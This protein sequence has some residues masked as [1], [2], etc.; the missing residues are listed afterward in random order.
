MK[1]SHAQALVLFSGLAIVGLAL[2][3]SHP[4][5]AAISGRGGI[6]DNPA[7]ASCFITSGSQ[8]QGTVYQGC[9][10]PRRLCFNPMIT[11]GGNHNISAEGDSGT[12]SCFATAFYPNGAQANGTSSVTLVHPVQSTITTIGTVNVPAFGSLSICCDMS[13]NSILSMVN[14]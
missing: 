8:S 7:D 9:P 2:V 14:F 13:F 6:P 1:K 11:N 4:S 3:V 12:V 10:S 5:K